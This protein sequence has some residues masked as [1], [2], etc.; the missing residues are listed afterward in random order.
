MCFLGKHVY[1]EAFHPKHRK[2]DLPCIIPRAAKGT[3]GIRQN[4]LDAP[5]PQHWNPTQSALL[6]V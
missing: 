2:L 6:S 3:K 5:C 4:G 1:Q